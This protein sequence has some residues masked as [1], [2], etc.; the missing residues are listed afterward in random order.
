MESRLRSEGCQGEIDQARV[1][2]D[3]GKGEGEKE[4][5][6]QSLKGTAAEEESVAIAR[7]EKRRSGVQK[8][9]KLRR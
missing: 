1:V 2:S 8:V 6:K 4:D 5:G 7:Q 9:K 3:W